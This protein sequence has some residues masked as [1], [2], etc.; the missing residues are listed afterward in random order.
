MAPEV[1]CVGP[2]IIAS[3]WTMEH[4]IGDLGS[5]IRQPSNPYANLSQY[6]SLCYQ[7]NA[8][9]S[10]FPELAP[11]QSSLPSRAMDL[12]GGYLLLRAW[13]RRL[14]LMTESGSIAL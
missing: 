3:Q 9:K 14:S 1:L 10:I 8:L 5:E 7:V 13:E 6:V 11:P 4:A 2:G 12:E